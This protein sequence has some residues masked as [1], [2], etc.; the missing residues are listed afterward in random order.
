MIIF[1]L[2]VSGVCIQCFWT[3]SFDTLT[4]GWNTS[5]SLSF[6][7]TINSNKVATLFLCSSEKCTIFSIV[8]TSSSISYTYR[9][10]SCF[11]S[12]HKGFTISVCCSCSIMNTL[13]F[14]TRTLSFI[15]TPTSF[16]SIGSFKRFT[17][18]RCSCIWSTNC[19][20]FNTSFSIS[21][22]SI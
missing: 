17:S 10:I 8:N 1:T 2:L 16:S 21:D 12:R 20:L 9:L 22:T 18:S 5:Y 15:K 7:G 14:N 4:F 13:F 3:Y 6:T 19:G 11:S